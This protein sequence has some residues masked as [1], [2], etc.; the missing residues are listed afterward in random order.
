MTLPYLL[1]LLGKCS[2]EV[3][4]VVD[5]RP[6]NILRHALAVSWVYDSAHWQCWLAR[7]VGQVINTSS[8]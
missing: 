6:A 3:P 2:V 5:D 4:V 1:L 7:V 8:H